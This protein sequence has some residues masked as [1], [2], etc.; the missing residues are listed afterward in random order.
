M[1]Q[2]VKAVICRSNL[3]QWGLVF[4]MYAEDNEGYTPADSREWPNAL[5]L[6]YDDVECLFCC[7][8]ATKLETE[9]GRHPFAAFG[10]FSNWAPAWSRA[11]DIRGSYGI[12]GWICNP[13]TEEMI[14]SFDLPTA[15]NF[16]KVNVK[17]ASNIPLLLDS[18]W[19][20]SYPDSSNEPP[21]FD[22]D[23]YTSGPMGNRQMRF[24]CIN[25][26][27]RFV[28]GLFLDSSVRKI[29]LKELWT[30]KWHRNCEV[31]ASRPNWPEWM[32]GFKDY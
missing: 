7:P 8:M 3:K 28:N 19:V 21:D 4:S 22:G 11:G 13:P 25:R 18:M 23:F 29:G 12:N 2:R 20:D 26:H 15:N 9:G 27:N 1:K 10:I 30:L 6:Y 32:K 31:N 5:Q 16:R 14:N 24:F 17:G